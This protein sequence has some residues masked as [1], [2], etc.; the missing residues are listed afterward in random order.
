MSFKCYFMLQSKI[1]YIEDP[2]GVAW[3]ILQL[4]PY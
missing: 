1:L 3:V 2:I 4:F